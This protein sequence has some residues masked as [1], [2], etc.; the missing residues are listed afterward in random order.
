MAVFKH[1]TRPVTSLEWHPTDSTVFTSASEDD[2][3]IQWD[4]SVEPD[5]SETVK[6]GGEG[7][8]DASGGVSV[9]PQLLFI[10]QGQ[11]EVKEVHWHPQLTGVLITTALTGFNVFR[12]I[13]V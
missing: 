10:H 6:V 3:V 13:S 5:S 1:H 4:L 2:Q 9:P 8:D 11:R 7:G 12:T